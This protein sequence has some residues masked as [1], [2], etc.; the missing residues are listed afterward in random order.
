MVGKKKYD[1]KSPWQHKNEGKLMLYNTR[2]V[3]HW[4]SP[5]EKNCVSLLNPKCKLLYVQRDYVLLY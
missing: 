2:I 5:G 1:R 3:Y 4:N